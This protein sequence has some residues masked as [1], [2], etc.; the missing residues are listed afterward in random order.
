MY[1]APTDP[2]FVCVSEY[3]LFAI[4]SQINEQLRDCVRTLLSPIRVEGCELGPGQVATLRVEAAEVLADIG[5]LQRHRLPV[6]TVAGEQLGGGKSRVE[7]MLVSTNGGEL[8]R[9]AAAWLPSYG[10]PSGPGAAHAVCAPA[11]AGVVMAIA[12]PAHVVTWA[13]WALSQ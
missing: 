9:E 10:L 2:V 11:Q 5:V 1:S 13:H 3:T 12:T 4:G 7:A 8:R 6:D